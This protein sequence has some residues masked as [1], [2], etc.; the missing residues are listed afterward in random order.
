MQLSAL[1]PVLALIAAPLADARDHGRH[2]TREL[3]RH[4][5][6]ARAVERMSAAFERRDQL[7][8]EN[9]PA[10]RKVKRASKTC[11]VRP[12]AS[13]SATDA[14]SVSAAAPSSTEAPA[15]SAAAT[16]AWSSAAPASTTDAWSSAAP[17]STEAA[18][19]DPQTTTEAAASSEAASASSTSS[20]AQSSATSINT[21]GLTPRNKKSGTSGTDTVNPFGDK[22]SWYWN[23]DSVPQMDNPPALFMPTLWGAGTQGDQ[24]STRLAN[25]KAISYTPDYVQ[26][27]YE[28]DCSPPMSS[29]IDPYTAAPLWNELIAPF[30]AKGSLLV[31][32][33]MCK[34]ADEDWLTP[35]KNQIGDE[36]MW[37]ITSV[38]INKLDMDGVRKVLDHYWNTYGKPMWVTE[39]A[40]VDDT[41]GFTPCT[42]QSQINSYINQIVPLFESDSRVYAYSISTGEGLGDVWPSYKDGQL[43]ETGQTYLNAIAA[44]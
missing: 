18:S 8:R 31:S 12:S 32:P 4:A 21:G 28:P 37:D 25:F 13:A 26:G 11:R 17:A 24:D 35:F 27:F 6:H 42:D 16:D 7:A 38:H 40:C 20:A 41:N 23:Y 14:A 15:S 19:A 34:Q 43:T 44:Y 36:N 10:I 33:G 5:K 29:A 1:L 30:K 39:F 2:A 3:G 22:I 9:P